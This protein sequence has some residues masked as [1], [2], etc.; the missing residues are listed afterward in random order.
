MLIISLAVAALVFVGFLSLVG[1]PSEVETIIGLIIAA[2]AF[3]TS[4]IIAWRAKSQIHEEG[5]NERI[6][7]LER[8]I[9]ELKSEK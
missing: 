3:F 2:I 6:T 4:V 1:S 9:A 8:E 5:Q 7:A